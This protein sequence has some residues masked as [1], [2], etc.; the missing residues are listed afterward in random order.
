MSRRPLALTL[1]IAA[2]LPASAFAEDLLQTYDL[3]R[4]GDPTYSAAEST[5]LATKEGA[6]QARGALLP[7]INGTAGL[8]RSH[9]NSKDGYTVRQ[10]I[11]PATGD[12]VTVPVPTNGISSSRG[13]SYGAS[14]S[15][16]I[17]DWGRINTLRSQ[18]ELS[19]AADFT[20]DNAGGDLITRT[21]AAYFNVL[22]QIETLAANEAAEAAAKRQF[23]Y[24][25][26]RLEV[27]L[28]PITDVHEARAEY[29]SARAATILQRNALQD[30]YQALTEITGTRFVNLKA[31]PDDFRPELPAEQSADTWVASALEHNPGLKAAEYQT[32]SAEINVSTARAGHLPTLSLGANYDRNTSWGGSSSSSSLFG[33]GS[34]DGHS[35]SIGLTLN[36]PI[37]SGGVTQSQV[38]QAIA[39]RDVARDQYEQQ[40]RALERNTRDAYQT[41]VAGVSEVEARRLAVVS[42]KAAYDAS[43]VGLEVGTRT[44]LDVLI[45]QRTL[46][47]AQTQYAQAKYNFLQNRLLLDQAAGSLD[48]DDLRDVNRLLTADASAQLSPDKVDIDLPSSTSSQNR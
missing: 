3:A 22:V 38:R 44:V 37:F 7:Q 34:S 1:A 17:F 13:R 12:L 33:S 28:A 46:L 14:L 32:R 45:N 39:N 5:R 18:R 30:A 6:V 40:K 31:L 16:S 29:D 42:A 36:I 23:E 2:L 8:T 10:E 24:A 11:D 21:S 20:L 19:K 48:I 47:Q 25:D 4:T 27:G 15:Q 41:L 43:Q 26:K 9:S 35:R